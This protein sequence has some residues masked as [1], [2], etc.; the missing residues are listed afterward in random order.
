MFGI[1]LNRLPA[2]LPVCLF[3]RLPTRLAA[4]SLVSQSPAGSNGETVS[5]A[6]VCVPGKVHLTKDHI[7]RHKVNCLNTLKE[8]SYLSSYQHLKWRTVKAQTLNIHD[9]R[10]PCARGPQCNAAA[11]L[12]RSFNST[13]VL[14]A[15][16][17][18]VLDY[19]ALHCS[20]LLCIS[21]FIFA[22]LRALLLPPFW[23][24][25]TAALVLVLNNTI[26]VEAIN[27]RKAATT[28][29][30]FF[31]TFMS[32]QSQDICDA[33]VYAN[34][35]AAVVVVVCCRQCRAVGLVCITNLK[36]LTIQRRRLFV[37]YCSRQHSSERE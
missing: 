19:F 35:V 27:E 24:L 16:L 33:D 6:C 1:A 31:V 8:I 22:F 9:V 13:S 4:A 17:L 14:C 21:I 37:W 12:S 11:T 25:F 7:K 34:M 29:I 30:F 26:H 20:T 15:V 28:T 36:L 10:T 2:C 32:E 5:A 18:D 23:I 3:A